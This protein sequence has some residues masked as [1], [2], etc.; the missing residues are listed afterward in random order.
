MKTKCKNLTI[1]IT[2]ASSGIGEALSVQLRRL[3]LNIIQ[4]DKAAFIKRLD[5]WY[6]THE[7]YLNERSINNLYRYNLVHALL[8]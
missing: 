5:Y 4:L 6:L 7:A 8:P 2:G 1:W 3:A